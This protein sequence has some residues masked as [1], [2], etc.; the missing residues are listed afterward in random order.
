MEISAF[1]E[2]HRLTKVWLLN[3][4]T[5]S[6]IEVSESFLSRI[7]SGERNSD[8]ACEIRAVCEKICR[9]YERMVDHAET[10]EK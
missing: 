4:L 2:R 6:G 8:R 9:E 3:R 7:I 5:M 1:L 10:T